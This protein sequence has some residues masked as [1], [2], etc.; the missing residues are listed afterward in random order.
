MTEAALKTLTLA[1]WQTRLVATFSHIEQTR[2]Q[3]VPVLNPALQ[4]NADHFIPWQDY[5]LGVMITPWFMNLM[6]APATA[7]TSQQF[8]ELKLGK[9]Q[10][11]VFPSGPYE[12]IIGHEDELGFFQSCSLFS[13]MFDF[14]DQTAAL[15]TAAAVLQELMKVENLEELDAG[16]EQSLHELGD[17]QDA[18]ADREQGQ[19]QGQDQAQDNG[20]FSETTETTETTENTLKNAELQTPLEQKTFSRRQLFLGGRK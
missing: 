12:F 6:L 3:G 7:E 20:H 14:A 4:V 13:P 15:D 9:K 10:T 8:A 16:N 11:H 17:A 5:F 2:M 1:D 18:E 19:E